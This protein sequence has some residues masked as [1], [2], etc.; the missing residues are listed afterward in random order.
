MLSDYSSLCG[1]GITHGGARGTIG[2]E[3]R[4]AFARQLPYLLFYLQFHYD[5][6]QIKK[7]KVV[8]IL[9]KEENF[10]FFFWHHDQSVGDSRRMNSATRQ[11][12]SICRSSTEDG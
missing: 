7:Q 2:T 5:Q 6:C 4:S 8:P 3:H 11:Q 12:R 10:F 9:G 1:V